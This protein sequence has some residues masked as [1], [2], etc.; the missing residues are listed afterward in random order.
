MITGAVREKVVFGQ[1]LFAPAFLWEDL[2]SFAVIALHTLYLYGLFTAAFAPDALM[3]IA[4]AAS[5][6]YAINVGQFILKLRRAQLDYARAAASHQVS[7]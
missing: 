1:Y 2:F 3:F 6:T 5:L 4:L 7:A